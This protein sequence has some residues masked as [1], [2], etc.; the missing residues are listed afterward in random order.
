MPVHDW[1]RVD[2]GTFHGFHTA[3]LTHL[4]EALN[5]G[6]LP[7]GYY[8]LPEHHGG[9][10]I[11]DVLTLHVSPPASAPLPQPSTGGLALADAPPKVHHKRTVSSAARSRQ[12]AL[13]IR[14]VTGQ[15]IVA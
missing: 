6:R 14:H 10:L 12:P 1:T 4:S 13:P 7:K 8:A 2:A 3:W 15:R 11:A 9:R 5:A